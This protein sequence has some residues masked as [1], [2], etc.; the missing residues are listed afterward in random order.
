MNVKIT[1]KSVTFKITE[2]EMAQLLSGHALMQKVSIGRSNFSMKIDPNT[3]DLFEEFKE[4][5]LKVIFDQANSCL[6]LCTTRTE[7]QKLSDMGR[8]RDG[9]SARTGGLNIHL[10]VDLRA[11]SRP[12]KEG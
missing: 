11:D 4:A 7:I 10:Q 2:E 6:M 9:L 8:S 12:R 3:G 5:S 1:E